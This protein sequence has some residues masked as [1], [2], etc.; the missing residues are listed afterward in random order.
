MG[1]PWAPF[2]DICTDTRQFRPLS[3]Y[4]AL[5]GKNFDGHAYVGEA[6]EKGAGGLILSHLDNGWARGLARLPAVVR[7][8]D[9]LVALQKL[10]SAHRQRYN[11]MVVGV[12]GSNGKTT[13]KEMLGQILALQGPTLKTHGNLNNH[14]G[15]PFMILEITPEHR[16]AVLEMGAS[17]KGDI[18]LL[19]TL[20]APQLGIITNIG[21]A[22]LEFFG[23]LEGT[24]QAK[25]EL[26]DGVSSG[27]RVVLNKD[28][29]FLAKLAEELGSRA[30]TFGFHPDAQVRATR[31]TEEEK[32][33][34]DLRANGQ[35]VSVQL[36]VPGRFNVQN[37]LAAAAAALELGAPLD[38]IVQGLESFTNVAMRMQKKVLA[39]GAVVMN[40][41]YNANPASMRQGLAGFC[42]AYPGREKIAVL[43]DMLELGSGSFQEHRD[44]LK[45][46]QEFPLISV[47][48]IGPQMKEAFG[49][50]LPPYFRHFSDK[51][52][53]LSA[54][55]KTVGPSNAVFVKGSR[56]M[57][58]EEIVQKL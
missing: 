6:Q 42:G 51:A 41:A 5:K 53:M 11:P 56:G 35:S 7:V 1:D 8:P 29:P 37:A 24:F 27:S 26:A 21:P 17:Q 48:L 9:T 50:G 25:R 2:R 12:T 36:P 3:F 38:L 16:F 20:A 43:G 31:V 49:P 52:E 14:I 39:S 46:I 45:K 23:S 47:F 19:A 55:R 10:A 4:L 33:H 44:L 28:D 40:D 30:I 18:A 32:T 57:A 34:F 54:L 13:V 15:L 58:L 22:H